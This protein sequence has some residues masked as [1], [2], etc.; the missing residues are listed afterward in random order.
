MV[1]SRA[2]PATPALDPGRLL[3]RLMARGHTLTELEGLLHLSPGYLSKLRHERARPSAQLLALLA[4]LESNPATTMG[5]LRAV[6]RRARGAAGAT[7]VTVT[8]GG[9]ALPA[10]LAL[11]PELER[12]GVPWALTGAVALEAHGL[13]RETRDVD[14]YV[15]DRHRAVLNVFRDAGL[16]IAHFSDELAAAY[17]HGNGEDDR[18]DLIFPRMEPAA[19]MLHRAVR[20]TLRGVSVPVLPALAL[21]A[22][23]LMSARAKEHADALRLLDAGLTT[24]RA[25]RAELA[26]LAKGDER[27]DRWARRHFDPV[28]ALKRLE[29]AR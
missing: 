11:V 4:L 19:T 1:R 20:R 10:L 24:R 23:K 25:L 28:S 17:P 12:R 6:G 5:A 18:I 16:G 9:A 15:D 3:T 26:R 21:T 22:I 8:G 29:A 7:P 27:G 2:A 13:P 14:L